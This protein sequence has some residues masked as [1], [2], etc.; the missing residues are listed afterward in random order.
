MQ[1]VLLEQIF[2]D[3]AA[4]WWSRLFILYV[5]TIGGHSNYLLPLCQPFTIF[6]LKTTKVI[7]CVI[8]TKHMQFHVELFKLLAHLLGK[9]CIDTRPKLFLATYCLALAA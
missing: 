4:V 3:N 6:L 8:R 1:G 5:A 7:S 9:I 2:V